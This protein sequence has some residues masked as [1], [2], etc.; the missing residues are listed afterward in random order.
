MAVGGGFPRFRIAPSH[1]RRRV[2]TCRRSVY[3]YD[4]EVSLL[5]LSVRELAILIPV[6]LVSLTVHELAHAAVSLALGDDTAQRAGRVT[7]NPLRHV[8]PFGFLLLIVAGF[9]WAKPVTFDRSKLRSPVRD[10][11]LVS[12]AGP[13]SNLALAFLGAVAIRLIVSVTG[14]GDGFVIEAA[15]IFCSINIVLAVFNALPVPPLDGSHVYMAY[16]SQRNSAAALALS[17]YGFL[18]LIVLIFAGRF[19]GVDLLPIRQI[20]QAILRGMLRVVG[21]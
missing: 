11:I 12:L 1:L 20:T 5:N 15:F 8:D 13:G 7:L 9:G 18:L 10:E 17:R 2:D 16:L 3:P 19:T 4:L 6:I 14:T 21:V